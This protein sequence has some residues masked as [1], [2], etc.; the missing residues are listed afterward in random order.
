MASPLVQLSQ[1]SK[2][3]PKLTQTHDRL[4]ALWNVLTNQSEQ[5]VYQIL[6]N[7]ELSVYHGESLG[8][9]GENGAGK[10]TLLKIIA[11]VIKPTTGQ[12][13][14]SGRVNA[15]LELGAGFHP[16]YSGKDNIRLATALMGLSNTEMKEHLPAI[17]EFADLR[18][19]INE[20]V[21]H[22]SSGMI[23]RLGFAV[24]TAVKPDLLIT[25]EVLAV[26]D[27]SFQKKCIHW[28]E[29][30]LSEGGTLLL[31]SHAMF[32]IQKLCQKTC[33]IHQGRIHSYGDT[34][35]ITQEYLAYHEKKDQAK[36][37]QPELHPRQNYSSAYHLVALKIH[38]DNSDQTIRVEMGSDLQI[39]AQVYSPDD[40]APVVGF[41]ILRS[42]GQIPIY[43]VTSD[44]DGFIP[45]HLEKNLFGFCLTLN[46]LILLPGH[47]LIRIH[48]LD[49][50]GLRIFDTQEHELMI[51]GATREL[52]FCRLNHV[53]STYSARN[54]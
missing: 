6:K 10:S 23:V 18:E 8:I 32:H 12:V 40:R 27:E 44:M 36:P 24:M 45:N 3:Y 19:Y 26:G 28:I 14:V 35:Q 17:I 5:N 21:K 50:E 1:V 20:P 4:R 29:N 52:G 30:Y 39:N 25:D 15:L 9:I 54:R 38:G 16:E 37:I 47:Y 48:I 43:G 46:Q 49:P 33:W 31:C 11:G 51:V 42:G 41:G 7:I 13:I 22:Y 2:H 53:W 34:F